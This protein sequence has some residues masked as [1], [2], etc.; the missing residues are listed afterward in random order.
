MAGAIEGLGTTLVI[1]SSSLCYI[2]LAALG[3]DGGEKLDASCLDN[4]E[5]MTFLPQ[6][7]KLV[8]DMGFTAKFDPAEWTALKDEVNVNQLLTIAFDYQGN[9]LGSIA[10][11]GYLKAFTPN[12]G[13][14]GTRWEATGTIVVTNMNASDVETGPVYSA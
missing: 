3:I 8:P 5:W 7:L 4:T 13:A 6:T 1:G 9:D 2:T 11:W 10:F 12:E 14:I